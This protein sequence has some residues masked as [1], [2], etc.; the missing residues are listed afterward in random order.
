MPQIDHERSDSEAKELVLSKYPNFNLEGSD[1]VR[2]NQ[3]TQLV[4]DL[5]EFGKQVVDLAKSDPKEAFRLASD[6]KA[7]DDPQKSYLITP[8]KDL[9]L[10][11]EG[12]IEQVSDVLNLGDIPNSERWIEFIVRTWGMNPEDFRIPQGQEM[13]ETKQMV[14]NVQRFAEERGLSQQIVLWPNAEIFK[15]LYI[16]EIGVLFRGMRNLNQKDI[17]TL[18]LKGIES[19]A[20]REFNGDFDKLKEELKGKDPNYEFKKHY[21]GAGK[22]ELFW[23]APQ[24]SPFVAFSNWKDVPLFHASRGEKFRILVE[25][26]PKIWSDSNTYDSLKDSPQDRRFYVGA[27]GAGGV[28]MN[29]ALDSYGARFNHPFIYVVEDEIAFYPK[30]NFADIAKIHIIAG[31]IKSKGI[32]HQ[33][34]TVP[35]ARRVYKLK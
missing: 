23:Q 2:V 27:S 25:L 9:M 15:K 33:E 11:F 8:I 12:D 6:I 7:I 29:M 34:E 3:F 35:F 20:L 26:K 13:V 16:P 24:N 19:N 4:D 22:D 32:Y 31:D 1:E 21:A 18:L 14:R 17:E 5:A 10:L 30:V 28:L